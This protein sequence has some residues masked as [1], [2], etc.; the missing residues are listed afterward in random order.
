MIQII[1]ERNQKILKSL[2]E[3]EGVHDFAFVFDKFCKNNIHLLNN[4]ELTTNLNV[5]SF[6]LVLKKKI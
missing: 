4:Y 6:S 3:I 5:T 2:F 1:V